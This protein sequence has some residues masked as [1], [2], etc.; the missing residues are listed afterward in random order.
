[1]DKSRLADNLLL[2]TH[3]AYL[4]VEEDKRNGEF[5]LGWMM[6]RKELIGVWDVFVF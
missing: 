4:K 5:Y 1:M 3:T 2:H 6:K